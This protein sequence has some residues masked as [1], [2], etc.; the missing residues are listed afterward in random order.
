MTF[1][2]F[3]YY[4]NQNKYNNV[5]FICFEYNVD[6]QITPINLSNQSLYI[7]NCL[8]DGSV[9]H[10]CLKTWF[11][12]EHSCPICRIKVIENDEPIIDCY[13]IHYRI[14][15]FSK[16]VI[17]K[18]FRAAFVLFVFYTIFELYTSILTYKYRNNKQLLDTDDAY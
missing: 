8:C 10:N 14:I 4:N 3:T 16:L 12:K 15:D 2:I 7:K 5:C 18:F 13:Y 1:N 9:H 17:V 6:E 11:D